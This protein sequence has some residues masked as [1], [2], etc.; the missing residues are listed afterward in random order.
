MAF[1]TKIPVRFEDVDFAR[2][3][4][5]PRLFNYC[6]QVFED[7]FADAVGVTYSQMLQKRKVGYP[8][9]HA[10]ADFKHPLRFGDTARIVMETI[11]LSSK[12]ITN[13]Y[14][15]YLGDT[16]TLCAEVEIVTVPIDMDSFKAREIPEDV[17]VAF[18]N[19]LTG[20]TV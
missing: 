7:F 4:F 12:S 1:I 10:S 17:R 11:K 18:L 3:V 19:H 2:V 5:F 8:S 13:R 9:V 6:H 16:K 20:L 15:L 14:R